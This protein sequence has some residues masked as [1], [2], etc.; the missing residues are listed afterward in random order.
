M[1]YRNA[2]WW[3]AF[4]AVVTVVGFWDS[5][6]LELDTVPLAFHAHAVT[7]LAWIGLAGLQSWTIHHRRHALHRMTGKA[8]F[9][10]FPLLM[11][12]F[13]GGHQGDDAPSVEDAR[14]QR[15]LVVRHTDAGRRV[16]NGRR[17]TVHEGGEP[18][19]QALDSAAEWLAAIRDRF[20]IALEPSAAQ[21]EALCGMATAAE[22]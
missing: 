7:A 21:L 6:F 4:V 12:S 13:V 11:A 16:L 3:A 2:H 5:Y 10:L 8:S 15:P 9:L 17:F 1:P 22:F 18:A 19:E 14:E 20:G